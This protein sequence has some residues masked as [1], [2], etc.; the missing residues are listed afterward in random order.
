MRIEVFLDNFDWDGDRE[1]PK[2]SLIYPKVLESFFLSD[3]KI[4]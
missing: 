3:W 4:I 1:K 2:S